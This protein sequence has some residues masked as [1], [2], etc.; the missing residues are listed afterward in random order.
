MVRL[1]ISPQTHVRATQGDAILFRIPKD[2]RQPGSQKRVE[3]LEKY[4]QYKEEL[5]WVAKG[6]RFEIPNSGAHIKFF[7]PVP[8]SWYHTKKTRFHMQP[9]QSKPDIDNLFKAM[10]DSLL[11][12]DKQIYDVRIS[13]FWV[14]NETGWIEIEFS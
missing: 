7:I 5:R 6:K 1:N 12:E 14:N 10:G 11:S 8:K 13:K 3:R 4:N 9:H 2:K